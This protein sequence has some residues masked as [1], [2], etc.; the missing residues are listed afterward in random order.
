MK[1]Y[2]FDIETQEGRTFQKTYVTN[3][4]EAAK[5][6]AQKDFRNWVAI[7]LVGGAWK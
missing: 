5:E 4:L 1:S 6:A 2:T 7:V 3:D